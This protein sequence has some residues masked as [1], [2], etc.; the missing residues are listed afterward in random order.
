MEKILEELRTES[1]A[2]RVR[3]AIFTAAEAAL[4]KHIGKPI[5]KRLAND[6]QALI[7]AVYPDSAAYTV[8]G[9][10]RYLHIRVGKE[11]ERFCLGMDAREVS[12]G[13]VEEIK[14]WAAQIAEKVAEVESL[15]NDSARLE[16]LVNDCRLDLQDLQN[17]AARV[18]ISK[19]R[20][21]SSLFSVVSA[22]FPAISDLTS[23]IY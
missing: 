15:L 6:A 18:K 12:A 23:R 19:S 11:L 16:N 1:A 13:K 22:E 4:R 2:L 14:K 21:S 20:L 5:G 7:Q 8:D 10:F 17:A 3:L 9:P